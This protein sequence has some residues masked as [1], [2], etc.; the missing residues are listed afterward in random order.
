MSRQFCEWGSGCGIS[1][2]IIEVPEDYKKNKYEL[3]CCEECYEEA[4]YLRAILDNGP[5]TVWPNSKDQTAYNL[6]RAVMW[7]E[8][9]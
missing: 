6:K 2:T 1:K 8:H 4:S 9:D 7:F 3:L 5:T